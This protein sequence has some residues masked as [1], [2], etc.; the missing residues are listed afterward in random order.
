MLL[1]TSVSFISGLYLLVINAQ[2]PSPELPHS[3]PACELLD[4]L[5]LDPS[6]GGR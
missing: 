3:D 5:L 6:C 4:L 1:T 2:W